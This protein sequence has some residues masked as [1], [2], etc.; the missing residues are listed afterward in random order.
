[1]KI[2]IFSHPLDFEV[3]LQYV[4]D[5]GSLFRSL[6]GVVRLP[7]SMQKKRD[8]SRREAVETLLCSTENERA[9]YGVQFRL[10]KCPCLVH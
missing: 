8:R 9:S 3:Q 1:M 6:S 5:S 2:R 10:Q 7:F 4:T